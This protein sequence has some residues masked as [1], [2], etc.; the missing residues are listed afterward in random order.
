MSKVI[1]FEVKEDDVAEIVKQMKDR[2]INMS[3][4]MRQLLKDFASDGYKF[5]A[6][7]SAI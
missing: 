3:G 2:R 5:K 7:R 1:S 6:D 4:A